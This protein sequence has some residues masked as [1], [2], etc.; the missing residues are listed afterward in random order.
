MSDAGNEQR[1]R[2]HC[3]NCM[4]MF[5]HNST[6]AD[7][8]S[9]DFGQQLSGP[10][11]QQKRLAADTVSKH[12]K[13]L[14]SPPPRAL[15]PVESGYFKK[16][17]SRRTDILSDADAKSEWFRRGIPLRSS[18][19]EDEK[20]RGGG[21]GGG[22][23]SSSSSEPFADDVYVQ[24]L[25]PAK[26][27]EE[28][29]KWVIGQ[30]QVKK[31]LS[32]GLFNHYQ[33]LQYNQKK[34]EFA[35]QQQAQ[36]NSSTRGMSRDPAAAEMRSMLERQ[37][38][39]VRRDVEAQRELEKMSSSSKNNDDNHRPATTPLWKQSYEQRNSVSRSQQSTSM[40]SDLSP[41]PSS[42]DEF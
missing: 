42:Q 7:L 3:Q 8:A 32:V 23:G 9:A 20:M 14:Q 38:N 11:Y 28:I 25:S 24:S 2:L 39:R 13:A 31:V 34:V 12:S 19:E 33:R 29:E 4:K 22:S 10:T 41:P 6:I 30:E 21:G 5:T 17:R 16:G 18:V 35:E 37:N 26:I 15:E 27:F 36:R 40:V 1:Y